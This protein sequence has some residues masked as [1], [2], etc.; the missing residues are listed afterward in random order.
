MTNDEIRTHQ[1]QKEPSVTNY[2]ILDELKWKEQHENRDWD[3]L[4]TS[5]GP[6]STKFETALSNSEKTAG[7]QWVA[8]ES[9]PTASGRT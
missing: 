1:L 4:I 3:D 5:Q 7:N 2:E 6:S 8:A 9:K